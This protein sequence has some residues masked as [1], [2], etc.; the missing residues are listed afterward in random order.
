MT[1]SGASY[2]QVKHTT[3]IIDG[4]R[5]LNGQLVT[6]T[7]TDAEVDAGAGGIY[8]SAD[9]MSRWMLMHLNNGRYGPQLT[10]QLFSEPVHKEMWTPQVIIPASRQGVYNTHF[11]AYGLGWLLIDV[12]GVEQ[13]FYTGQDD[14]MISQVA[15]IPEL[16][17]G[18]TVLSN[19]EGGGAVRS[20]IDQVTDFYLGI[21]GTDRVKEWADKVKASRQSA[22]QVSVDIW[23][24]VKRR[25]STNGAKPDQVRYIG[26]YQDN[27][28][29]DVEISWRQ[30][31][32]WFRSRR[33]PQL[34]GPM[35][36]YSDNT[37]IV[38]WEN[39]Q[40]QADAYVVFT[41]D[42]SGKAVG[43]RMKRASAAT[44]SA[45]DFQDLN[46]HR[47]DESQR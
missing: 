5:E 32:L 8:A 33:S 20:V 11:G 31:Q 21:S 4:H 26:H 42:E 44:S 2:K 15:L 38:R 23:E 27:W 18:I 25:P 30:Y 19:Q 9:D 10:Q 3:N 22:N 43:M 45:F 39:P 40:I 28:F 37:F 16:G 36:P 12:K 6:I 7:R 41:L 24:E 29:G 17:L 35:L 46:F 34:R 1:T 13:I 14:D 47:L